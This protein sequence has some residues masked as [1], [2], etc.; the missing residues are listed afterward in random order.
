MANQVNMKSSE[1]IVRRKE[2]LLAQGAM[3][4]S[5]LRVTKSEVRASLRPASLVQSAISSIAM[6]SY[7]ALKSRVQLSGLR[8][9]L[10]L[11]IGGISAISRRALIKPMLGGFLILGAV[12]TIASVVIKR[13]K[14]LKP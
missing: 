3:Y 11:L 4:R 5:A 1:S 10:P 14:A 2:S 12:S 6:F 7:A 9:V 8:A 13:K